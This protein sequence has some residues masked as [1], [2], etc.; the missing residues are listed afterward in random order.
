MNLG[1]CIRLWVRLNLT[2]LGKLGFEA[3]NTLGEKTEN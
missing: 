2:L 3:R 1:A